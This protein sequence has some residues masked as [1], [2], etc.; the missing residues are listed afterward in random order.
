[1]EAGVVARP[2]SLHEGLCTR[3]AGAGAQIGVTGLKWPD[4][5]SLH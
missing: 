5:Q 2:W 3:G 1:M 4:L